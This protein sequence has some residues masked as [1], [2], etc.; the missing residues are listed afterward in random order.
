MSLQSAVS[1]DDAVWKGIDGAPLCT[2]ST[3]DN[4]EEILFQLK[5]Q[6]MFEDKKQTA[7]SGAPG[8]E[9]ERDRIKNR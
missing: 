2:D 3:F 6:A 7:E 9:G 1:T 5:P 8:D 4:E